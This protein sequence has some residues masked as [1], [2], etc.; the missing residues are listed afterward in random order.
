MTLQD[1]L[2][3]ANQR[4]NGMSKL[5]SIRASVELV[6]TNAS[7]KNNNEQVARQK[8]EGDVDAELARRIRDLATE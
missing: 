2:T 6:A 7:G 4:L 1:G 5:F 3:L 8:R